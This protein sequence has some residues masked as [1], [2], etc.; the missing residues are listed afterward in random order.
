[1]TARR[2]GKLV[3]S[4]AHTKLNGGAMWK[5]IAIAGIWVGVGMCGLGGESTAVLAAAIGAAVG[6]IFVA[7]A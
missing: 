6:T 2:R 1:M 7:I 4:R 5:G 3:K